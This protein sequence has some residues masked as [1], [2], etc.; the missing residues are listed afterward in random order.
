MDAESSRGA[1][2]GFD[3]LEP[4]RFFAVSQDAAGWTVVTP[5]SDTQVIYVSSS[6][7]SDANDGLSQG[8]AVQTL[9]R[10]KVLVRDGFA[11]WMLLKRGDTFGSFTPGTNVAAAF[12]SRFTSPPTA[13]AGGR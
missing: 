12:K 13:P 10:G 2:G 3:L 7:G 6:T 8:S 9:T 4:R 5:A 1:W 11:D